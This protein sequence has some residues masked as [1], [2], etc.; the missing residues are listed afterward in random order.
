MFKRIWQG[1]L[2]G[3][4]LTMVLAVLALLSLG[5]ACIHATGKHDY[6]HKQ[7]FLIGLGICGFLAVNIVHYRKLGK[8]S[9]WFFV[10]TLFLLVIVL[11]GKYIDMPW[12]VPARK[13][14]YRWLKLGPLQIQPS[15]IAKLSYIL[16]LA[17]YLH[18]RRS[19]RR[20][21]GLVGP[22]AIT[23][24]PMALILLEPDL[25]T[26]LLFPPVLFA[27]LFAAGTKLRYLLII[28]VV[29]LA[30]SPLFYLK[31]RP[32]QQNRVK[33]LLKQ[34]TDDPFWLTGHG[35]QLHRSKICIGSG[36]LTGQGWGKG[37]YVN[38]DYRLPESRNLP[39]RHNDFIFALIGHQWGF[40]GCLV[41]LGLYALIILGGIEIASEQTEPFGRLLAFGITVLLAV[42]LWI[43]IA[44][45]MGLMPITGLTLPFISCGGSSL[46]SSFLALGL[47]VNVAR[48]RPPSR[49][50]RN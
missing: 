24:L 47:L 19:Y 44:M 43:N 45:T 16:T 7:L 12:L 42:Q 13:S 36:Q 15:E 26:A 35:L 32:Y 48:R 40:V 33:V 22:F 14:A 41:V 31:M 46:L 38:Y 8:L 20:I 27:V 29:G 3:L 34:G 17:W 5:L 18:N 30:L 2:G 28:I 1:R 21:S 9:G 6:F 49:I 11:A 10:L 50:A 39:E 37:I 25:G 23:L 4:R